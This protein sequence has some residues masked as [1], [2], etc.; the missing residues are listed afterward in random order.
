MKPF[1]FSDGK[2]HATMYGHVCELA[3]GHDGQTH[4]AGNGYSWDTPKRLGGR[5]TFHNGTGTPADW[6]WRGE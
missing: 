1:G 4:V 3:D 6:H 2:C 5:F